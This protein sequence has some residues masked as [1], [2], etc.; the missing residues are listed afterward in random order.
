MTRVAPPEQ[1]PSEN[2]GRGSDDA[3]PNHSDLYDVIVDPQQLEC[4]AS[5]LTMQVCANALSSCMVVGGHR[6]VSTYLGFGVC[7]TLNPCNSQ[8][9]EY[10]V[11]QACSLQRLLVCTC[12]F[13]A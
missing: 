5:D 9:A 10:N 1:S 7:L 11:W 8:L 2:S 12:L 13:R 4:Q 6:P 3:S